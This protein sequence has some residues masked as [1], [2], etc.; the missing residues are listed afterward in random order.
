MY[1]MRELQD[2][3]HSPHHLMVFEAAARKLSFTAAAV[4]LKVTQPAVSAAIRQLETAL[5]V[6]LFI[7]GHRCVT[8][9]EAGSMLFQDV[10]AGFGRILETARLLRRRVQKKHV[11]LSTSTAFANYWMVPRLADLHALHPGIDLRL[12]TTDKDLDLA[13][14]GVSLGI[15]RG[16][17]Q[18]R[19]Y[20]CQLIA[21]E[22]LFPVAS[23]ALGASHSHSE[24]NAL[25]AEYFI[26]LEEPYRP[27]PNWSDWFS[28]LGIDFKDD[29]KGLR[30]NDYALVIQAAMAGE[31]IALGWQHIVQ[32]LIEQKLLARIGHRELQPGVGFYLIWSNRAVLSEQAMA[33]RD[34]IINSTIHGADR[35]VVRSPR[36]TSSH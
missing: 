32:P 33:V 22:I 18:W 25:P 19:G 16:D 15:R 13:E 8:L 14:E 6:K 35:A 4:E 34:W 9:T 1:I 27:R 7:R 23:P 24:L 20:H 11:T 30:L 12:Q 29:G 36:E 31:G 10:A 2:L 21:Q 17:G 5:G 26:H 3:T 28:G